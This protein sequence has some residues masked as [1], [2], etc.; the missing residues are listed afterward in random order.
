MSEFSTRS[1]RA[2]RLLYPLI[3]S[4]LSVLWRVC[5]P[6]LRMT[7]Q[8]NIPRRGGVLIC[9]NHISDV[10]PTLVQ[11]ASPRI[12]SRSLWFMAKRELFSMK[13]P[14]IGE[15]GPKIEFFQTFP[16]DPNEPDREALRRAADILKAGQPLVVFPEG[17]CSLDGEMNEIQAG[18]VMLALRGN[19][20]IVPVGLWNTTGVMPYGSLIFRPTL[21]H[22]GIHF[23]KPLRFDDLK[24]KPKREAREIA[25]QRL[26]EA[27]KQARETAKNGLQDRVLNCG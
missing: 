18:A 1:S 22:V 9:P 25:T 21:Q 19:V 13:F 24:D 5:A 14:I 12:V 15:L 23:G 4:T 11:N 7:G 27:I 26:T 6:R 20:P 3:R 2:Y 8:N 16:V 17:F 10:D